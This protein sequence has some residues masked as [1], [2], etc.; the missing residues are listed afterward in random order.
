MARNSEVIRQ[1]HILRSLDRVRHGITVARLAEEHG[2]CARTIRR[3]LE[4]LCRAGFPLTDTKVNGTTMWR[5][6]ER[7]FHKLQELGLGLTELCALYFSRSLL[8]TLGGTLLLDET[9]HAF[10]KI[11]RALP[12]R[13]KEF[14]DRLPRVLQAKAR[15][16]KKQD[17]RRFP[18]IL[19]RVLDAIVRHRRASMRYDSRSS[20]RTKQ[21]VIEPQHIAYADGGI[22]VIGWVPEYGQMR[23]FA[24][25]RI[26][27]FA[28][29]DDTF[30]PRPLPT[31]PFADSLGVHTGTPETVVIE[32]TPEAAPY[33]RD[34]EWHPSQQ[35]EVRADGS[36][37]LTMRVC[38][39]HA[40]RAWVLGFGPAARVLAPESL[41][42]SI[43][44]AV[45]ETR[46]R[47]ANPSASRG[48]RMTIKAGMHRRAPA[49]SVPARTADLHPSLR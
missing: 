37:V 4:A 23:T 33:V 32:F 46:L 43:V 10:A 28:L 45:I 49:D 15:G 30:A 44:A 47:Y 29:L 27:T 18:D 34:R 5:L 36:V 12:A 42:Q 13:C 39:D 6:S 9:E 24:A 20:G 2:V 22:Y 1:W 8:H 19:A 40:L 11:E 38:N 35:L 17:D 48:V 7:P 14:V 31:A 25:E 41:K 16:R 21:Y 3:D 26:E